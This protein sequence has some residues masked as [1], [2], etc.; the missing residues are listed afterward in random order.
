[1]TEVSSQLAG[2][3]REIDDCRRLLTT[4]LDVN[5]RRATLRRL[6]EARRLVRELEDELLLSLME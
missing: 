5:D 3:Q 2:C 1:M 6:E 4:P